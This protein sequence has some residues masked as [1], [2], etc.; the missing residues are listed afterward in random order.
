MSSNVTAD[1]IIVGGGIVGAALACALAS[2]NL[3]IV[4]IDGKPNKTAVVNDL[5]VSAITYGCQQWLSA[6]GAWDYLPSESLGVFR[7]MKVWE[8]ADAALTFD[9]AY[10]GTP[11]LGYIVPNHLLHAALLEKLATFANVNILQPAYPT[12][13]TFTHDQVILTVNDQQISAKLIV[14]ADG[15]NSWV[16]QQCQFSIEEKSYQHTA[17]ITNI[18]LEHTHRQCAYQRFQEKNILGLLPLAD[19]HQGALVWSG[20][21]EPMNEWRHATDATFNNELQT[22]WGDS[23]GELQVSAPRVCIPLTMRHALNY[24]QTRVALIGDAAHTIHPL[25]GQGLNLGLWDAQQ[26]ANTIQQTR[27]K[28]RD[29]GLYTNLRPFERARRGHNQLMLNVVASNKWLFANPSLTDLRQAGISTLDKITYLKQ[30]IMQLA[31][32]GTNA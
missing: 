21:A 15:A 12:A 5:L 4:V 24:V 1:V 10:L 25:A 30:K 28:N 14:G 3:Q 9:S 16:R 20:E 2:I 18:H 19:P 13:A 32:F 8:K 27:N 26:L 11:T 17:L 22:L 7:S 31:V 23:L 6:I 29:F